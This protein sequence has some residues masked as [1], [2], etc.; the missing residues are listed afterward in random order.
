MTESEQRMQLLVL[1]NEIGK[2]VARLQESL[3]MLNEIAIGRLQAHL[4]VVI[5]EDRRQAKELLD[6]CNK[7]LKRLK[8]KDR[9]K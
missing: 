9:K 5:A 3:T 7:I 6:L 1:M 8:K 2:A 4:D